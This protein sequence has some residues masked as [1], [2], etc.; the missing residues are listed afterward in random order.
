VE[1]TGYIGVGSS[2]I[3]IFP[4]LYKKNREYQNDWLETVNALKL[5]K[6]SGCIIYFH[7]PAGKET[8]WKEKFERYEFVEWAELNY[9]LQ[10]SPL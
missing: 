5:H 2:V 1:V 10:I 4:K 3:R 6:K 9:L 7:V 8:E